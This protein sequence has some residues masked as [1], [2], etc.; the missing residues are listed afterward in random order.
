MATVPEIISSQQAYVSTWAGQADGFINQV[1]SLANTEF[2]SEA[3]N[4]L[5]LAA[6]SVGD[7][8]TAITGLQP[9]R[10]TFSDVT[11]ATAPTPPSIIAA[12]TTPVDIADFSGAA[13]QLDIPTAPVLTLPTAPTPPSTNSI[14]IPTAPTFTLPTAPTATSITVPAPPSIQ[15]PAFTAS[16]PIDDLVTPTNIFTFAE[17][18]YSSVILDTVKA[19]LLV[20]LQ[21]GGYGIDTDDEQALFERARAREYANMAAETEDALSSYA[22][23]GF[24]QEPGEAAITLQRISQRTHDKIADASRTIT[25]ERSRLYVENRQFTIREVRE[26]ESVLINYHNALMERTLNASRAVLDASIAIFN[27]QVARYN[28]RVQAYQVEASL[29]ES[30]IRAALTQVEIYKAQIEG[31]NLTLEGDRIRTE[32]YKAQLDGVQSV[33][34][35]YKAQMSAANIAADIERTRIEAFRGQIDAYSAQVQAKVAEFS[36]YEAGVRG[37]TARVEGFRA[38]VDAYRAQADAA[39][40]K[41]DVNVANLNAESERAR[42]QLAGYQAQ[43]EAYKAENAMQVAR[44]GAQADVYKADAAAFGS[45]VQG[46]AAG[47]NAVTAQYEANARYLIGVQNSKIEIANSRL[48]ALVAGAELR[49]GASKFGADFYRSIVAA[50]LG[51]INTLAAQISS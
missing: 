11:I 42:V 44:V 4:E 1:A 32:V 51:S 2:A 41:A 46:M 48:R 28:A 47:Y 26:L 36:A 9:V 37:Q 10:P 39:K 23:R 38:E 5:G 8:V 24:P 30:R 27:T 15:L 12:T 3:A 22:A 50:T 34:E 49:L 7:A 40:A 25:L 43:I 33:I 14:V 20:D 31:A 29:Y 13:P 17:E 18:R 16:A 6:Q 21:T 35:V 19:K 45:V